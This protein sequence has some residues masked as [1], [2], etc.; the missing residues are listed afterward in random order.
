M[1]HGYFQSYHNFLH[2]KDK[3]NDIIGVNHFQNNTKHMYP[4]IFED[5]KEIVGIHFRLGDY[6]HLQHA[7]PLLSNEYYKNAINSIDGIEH[8]KILV[9][10]EK[11]DDEEVSKRMRSIS[12]H[13]FEIFHCENEIDDLFLLSILNYVIMANSTFSW[14]AGFFNKNKKNI[15]IPYKWFYSETKSNLILP[16]WNIITY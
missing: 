2:N 10:C 11:E 9:F 15:Y 8:K 1:F 5:G 16:E 13:P 14:W 6:K 3:I 7:H 12:N 4:H